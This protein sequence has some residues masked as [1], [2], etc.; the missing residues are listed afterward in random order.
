MNIRC[1]SAFRIWFLLSLEETMILTLPAEGT[2]TYPSLCLL[3]YKKEIK[4]HIW[5]F[6]ICHL[7]CTISNFFKKNNAL[8]FSLKSLMPEWNPEDTLILLPLNQNIGVIY[9]SIFALQNL[10]ENFTNHFVL[11]IFWSG[12]SAFAI[13][14]W[15][16]N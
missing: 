13:Q 11:V 12:L 8:I 10:F 14:F 16:S 9:L 15:I 2:S 7:I 6:I 4:S 1:C 3:I 5:G